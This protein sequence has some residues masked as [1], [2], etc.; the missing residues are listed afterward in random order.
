MW[1]VIRKFIPCVWKRKIGIFGSAQF[2]ILESISSYQSPQWIM[3]AL[4]NWHRN[5]I[6]LF[7]KL[8]V[9][10]YLVINQYPSGWVI[11]LGFVGGINSALSYLVLSNNIY[12]KIAA[13]VRQFSNTFMNIAGNI[14]LLDYL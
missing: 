13:S 5:C 7:T 10:E 11:Q 2:G 9:Y 4:L 1:Q 6:Q 8:Q 3:T 12:F 14:Y